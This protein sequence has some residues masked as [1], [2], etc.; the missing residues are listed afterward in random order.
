MQ[1]DGVLRHQHRFHVRGLEGLN[2]FRLVLNR[3]DAHLA[4]VN[5]RRIRIVDPYALVEDERQRTMRL[6]IDVCVRRNTYLRR[7]HLVE[8]NKE[9]ET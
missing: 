3:I 7:F 5:F 9:T 6:N 2:D 1:R 4:E 8:G